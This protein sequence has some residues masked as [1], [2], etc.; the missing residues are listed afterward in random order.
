MRPQ[1]LNPL[2]KL[3][4]S[5]SGAE[6]NSLA[7]RYKSTTIS[8]VVVAKSFRV[9]IGTPILYKAYVSVESD[10]ELQRVRRQG[11]LFPGCEVVSLRW[12]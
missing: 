6:R 3:E 2:T 11:M 5:A 7:S 8:A 1:A 9:I 12:L 10:P 4:V